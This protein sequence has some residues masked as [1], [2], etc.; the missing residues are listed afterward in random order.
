MY[1]LC[2]LFR[3]RIVTSVKRHLSYAI[4]KRCLCEKVLDVNTNV[5]KDVILYKYI[6]DRYYKI[7]NLFAICQFSFWAYLSVFAFS[8]LRDAPVEKPEKETVWWRKINLGEN[9]Y[10]NG[11]SIL[12]FTIG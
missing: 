7:A 4:P 2:N 5:T 3:I 10:K 11:L 12:C 1:I 6:N 8:T 9:K